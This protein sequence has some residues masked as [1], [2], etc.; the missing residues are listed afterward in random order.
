MVKI[1]KF[2]VFLDR[3]GTINEEVDFLTKPDQLK[4][5]PTA[6]NAIKLLKNNGCIIVIVT[7]QSVV[8]RNLCTERE[9]EQINKKLLDLLASDGAVVDAIFYCPHHPEKN[10]S[11]AGSVYCTDCDCRKPK[12]GMLKAAA[13]KFNIPPSRCFM[14]GDSTRDIRAGISFGC[15]TFL[16][17]TG[18]GGKDKKYGGKPDYVCD[19]LYAAARIIVGSVIP[20]KSR[21]VIS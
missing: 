1:D 9:V 6:S 5:I 18:Y 7:N 15:T 21:V 13:T 17:K 12:I 8:A 16:V 2:L 20:A 19:D 10:H 3:D 4:L 11:K 14:V